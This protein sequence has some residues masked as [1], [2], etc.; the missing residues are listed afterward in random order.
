MPG[1][2]LERELVNSEVPLVVDEGAVIHSDVTKLACDA[3][4]MPCDAA[5]R[6][7]KDKWYS[8]VDGWQ[9]PGTQ[10]SDTEP[11]VYDAGHGWPNEL[12]RPWL[13]DVG[14]DRDGTTPISWYAEGVEQFFKVAASAAE[15]CRFVNR[16]AKPLLALPIV[17]TQGGGLAK[18]AGDVV[19]ELLPTLHAGGHRTCACA[20]DQRRRLRSRTDQG[21]GL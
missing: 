11:R 16:R 2:V 15:K 6:P 9:P 7:R 10:G 1:D 5:F 4:L 17:G 19:R 3:W 8:E 18:R 14:G 13:V 20:S 12:P 21:L